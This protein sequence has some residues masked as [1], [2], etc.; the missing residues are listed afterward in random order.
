[1]PSTESRDEAI[2]LHFY[3]SLA[4]GVAPPATAF[5]LSGASGASAPGVSAATF[6]ADGTGVK[7]TLDRALA[8]GETA[9]VS[10]A[11]PKAGGGLWDAEGKEL[12]S[13]SGVAVTAP[14]GV[15]A[16]AVV[17]DAGADDTYALGQAI[18]VAVTFSEAVDVEGAPRLKIDMD[19]AHWGT[20]WAVYEGGSGT[21]TLTFVHEVV[22][23]NIS[24]KGVAVLADTLETNGGAIRSAATGADAALGHPGL[25]H[26]AAH[27]VDWQLAPST[28]VSAVEVAS[29]PGPDGVWS[30]GETV[31]AAVTFSGAVTVETA[32]GTP[33]LALIVD[34]AAGDR[35]IRRASYASGSGTAR[36]V[37]AYRV[38]EADGSLAAVR[39]AA[40][41]LRLDGGDHRGRGRDGRPSSPSA[42]RPG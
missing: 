20:K 23:P 26:D 42:R 33:T 10:Y 24:T 19:P 37:F 6:S 32:S 2:N 34:E 21:D 31:E 13:F 9:T 15:T 14:E 29:E 8:P 22:K 25:G 1:M 27:K 16:V 4:T 12:A 41:G 30:E 18:R 39:V 7:L 5:S 17:S 3:R 35:T 28:E 11:R 36:L 38:V 40:S